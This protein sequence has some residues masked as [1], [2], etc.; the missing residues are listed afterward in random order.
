MGTPPSAEARISL[1]H[2]MLDASVSR[3][4]SACTDLSYCSLSETW[5]CFFLFFSPW[6]TWMHEHG[7]SLFSACMLLLVVLS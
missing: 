7:I 5:A 3:K 1:S 6:G 4:V 2:T